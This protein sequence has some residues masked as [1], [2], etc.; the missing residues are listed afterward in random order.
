MNFLIFDV[1]IVRW[2]WLQES[3]SIDATWKNAG[4]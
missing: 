3:G 1:S 4:C 2:S